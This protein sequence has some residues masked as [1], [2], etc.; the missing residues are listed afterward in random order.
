MF[1]LSVSALPTYVILSPTNTKVYSAAPVPRS[2][3]RP[4]EKPH[5]RLPRRPSVPS[6]SRNHHDRLDLPLVLRVSKDALRSSRGS[7][8]SNGSS[9]STAAL[10]SKRLTDLRRWGTLVF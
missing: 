4:F 2:M 5:G 9:C 7:V 6:P 1:F 3:V 8:C 10:C